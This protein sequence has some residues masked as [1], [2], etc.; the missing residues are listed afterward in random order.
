MFAY[1]LF[2]TTH[3]KISTTVAPLTDLTNKNR[4][5]QKHL[6]HI[7]SDISKERQQGLSKRNR[8]AIGEDFYQCPTIKVQ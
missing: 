7:R 8:I 4:Q 5:N 6:Q 1:D 3:R 2:S